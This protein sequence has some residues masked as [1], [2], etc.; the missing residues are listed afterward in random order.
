MLL[1][2]FLA[3]VLLTSVG[4]AVDLSRAALEQERIQIAADAASLAAVTAL[5]SHTDYSR[6][7]DIATSIASANSVSSDEVN[8]TPP[9]CGTWA[10]G[11]F[12]PQSNSMCDGTSTAVEVTIRRSLPLS[13]GRIISNKD[14]HLMARSVSHKTPSVSG[15]CIRPFGIEQSYLSLRQ[16]SVGSALV[17]QGDQNSG[18]WGKLDLYGNSSSGQAY[19]GYMLNN[20][21]DDSIAIGRAVS[22]GTGNADIR[23]VFTTILNDSGPPYAAENMVLAVTSD[24]GKGNGT[25]NILSFVRADLLSQEGS[26]SKWRAIFRIVD[27]AA[28]PDPP[29][30]FSQRQLMQ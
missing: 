3:V 17:V 24:F 11:A 5:S 29:P 13:F 10:H 4:L 22:V 25:V 23:Q 28:Q 15:Q 16:P 27:L 19:T 6:V 2:L 20:L 9:R 14:F 8:A 7:S 21:C 26:G 30:R 1:F 12:T 18:N